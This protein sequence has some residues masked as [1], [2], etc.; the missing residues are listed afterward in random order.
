MCTAMIYGSKKHHYFGRNLDLEH[1][2]GES[3]VITPRRFSFSL[4][5]GGEMREHYAMIGAATVVGGYPLYY[6]AVNEHGLSMAGLNFVGNAHF[7]S[8][9][10]DGTDLAQ[11]ELLPYILGTCRDTHEARA[12]LSRINLVD[13]PF[14]DDLPPSDLHYMLADRSGRSL[15][16]EPLADGCKIY[17]NVVGVLTNNPPFPFQ[18]ENLKLYLNVTA[19]EPTDR[20]GGFFDL[21]PSSRGMGAFGLPGDSSSPSRFVRA[22]FNLANSVISDGECES[23][24]QFFHLLDSV[25]QI[26]GCVRV[27]GGYERTQYSSCCNIDAGIYYYKTYSSSRITAVRLFADSLDGS[28][29]SVFPFD[30]DQYIKYEN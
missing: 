19:N 12:T 8:P 25:A 16:F 9:R 15:V 2:Y 22:A 17:D 13:T 29:L 23:V 6:D 1:T 30:T 4:R 3:V 10:G 27:G 26:E 20:F 7:Y 14:S 24:S 11:F 28:T 21:S 18:L 5:S